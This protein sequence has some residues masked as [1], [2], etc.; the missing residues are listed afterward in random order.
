M[1]RER[2]FTLIEVLLAVAILAVVV[3]MVYAAFERT[4]TL[5]DQ[6]EAAAEPYR[7]ARL[8]LARIS[9]EVMSTFALKNDPGARFVGEDGLTPDGQDADMLSFTSRSR[10]VPEGLPASDENAV[11][12]RL[13]GDRLIH[14]EVLNPLGSGSGNIQ[15]L[16]LAEGLAGFKLRYRNPEDGAWRD[17][18]D[19]AEGVTGLPDAV[20]VTLLFPAS[21]AE[22]DPD[23]DG[24]LALSALVPVPMGGG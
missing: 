14:T 4:A 9:D 22:G 15:S 18:W 24:Y 20:E 7:T 16:P 5:G 17:G 6:I 1:D 3:T 13:E 12:Y 23:R 21:G 2:G 11:A 19:P 8:A 10:A